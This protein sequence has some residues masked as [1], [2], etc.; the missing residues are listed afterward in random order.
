M[1]N[2]VMV[3]AFMPS[4]V[5]PLE[6]YRLVDLILLKK[7]SFEKLLIKKLNLKVFFSSFRH[8][9]VLIEFQRKR[10]LART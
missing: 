10:F 6:L 4:V 9:Q 3:N 1:L 8:F 2:V 5:A 7:T